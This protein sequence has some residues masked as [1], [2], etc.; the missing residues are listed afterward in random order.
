MADRTQPNELR[1]C[2]RCRLIHDGPTDHTP[3][4]CIELLLVAN[5]HLVDRWS[6]CAN[7]LSIL[8]ATGRHLMVSG[9]PHYDP[10]DVMLRFC[11]ALAQTARS[12]G[13]M[14][15]FD[16][17]ERNVLI[18]EA[19]RG[20]WLQESARITSDVDESIYPGIVLATQCVEMLESLGRRIAREGT[21]A[22]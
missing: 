9:L 7:E 15:H 2:E 3:D 13:A 6:G 11:N 1:Q 18:V 8:K 17:D 19:S 5:K 21:D 14:V 16:S 12:S 20:G 4:E 22:D 10:V